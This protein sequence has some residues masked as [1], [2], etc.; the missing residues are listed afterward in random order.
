MSRFS[1]GPVADHE[2]LAR[3]IFSPVHV[4]NT[5][6]I[7]PSA[8]SH[9]ADRGCS[10]QRED[11]APMEQSA[12]FVAGYLTSNV[13][14]VWKG[15]LI[16]SCADVRKIEGSEPGV[17]GVCVFDSAERT[18][19]AHAELCQTHHVLDEADRIELRKNLFAAF[20]HGAPIAPTA[21]RQGFVWGALGVDLQSR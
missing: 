17:R 20:G 2:K 21:Y 4:S 6:K 14:H 19:P 7:K 9:V 18:S 13:K 11:I 15:V 16:A 3:F 12:V 1:P 10:I 5:G 8:F